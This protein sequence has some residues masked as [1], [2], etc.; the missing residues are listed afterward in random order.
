MFIPDIDKWQKLSKNN[1]DKVKR[2]M[3]DMPHPFIE[4]TIQ[5]FQNE[6]LATKNKMIF[7]HFNHTNPI[8]KKDSK[9]S[10]KIKKLGFTFTDEGIKIEL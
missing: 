8:L 6:T 10:I 9:A 4:E 7:I 5:L 2:A 3:S 1:I